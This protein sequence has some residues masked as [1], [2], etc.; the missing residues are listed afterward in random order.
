MCPQYHTICVL[1]GWMCAQFTNACVLSLPKHMRPQSQE[2]EGAF[3]YRLCMCWFCVCAHAYFFLFLKVNH[4]G[5]NTNTGTHTHAIY[6][7]YIRA[8]TFKQTST[9]V[10]NIC[11]W[12]VCVCVCVDTQ[13]NTSLMDI[14]QRVLFEHAVIFARTRHACIRQHT[15]A[16]LSIRHTYVSTRRAHFHIR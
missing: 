7:T 10:Q 3:V 13:V 12:L 14:S 11:V 9:N 16:Y 2:Q 6:T 15:S 4:A 8:Y 5:K 1:K